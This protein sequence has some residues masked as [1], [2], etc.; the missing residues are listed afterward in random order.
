MDV[1]AL[2]N[3]CPLELAEVRA[4]EMFPELRREIEKSSGNV[5]TAVLAFSDDAAFVIAESNL[6][7]AGPASFRK[8]GISVREMIF[9]SRC[10]FII[11]P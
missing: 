4:V 11:E 7:P 8:M 2:I 3:A 9:A 10:A 5:R 1:K 6:R